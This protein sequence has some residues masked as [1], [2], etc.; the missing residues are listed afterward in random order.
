MTYGYEILLDIFGLWTNPAIW[1]VSVRILTKQ[2]AAVVYDPRIHA[3]LRLVHVS[4][5]VWL[6]SCIKGTY[7]RLEVSIANRNTAG[8]HDTCKTERNRREHTPTFF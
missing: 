6:L 4:F 2:L 7:T 5:C 3:E 1:V 8:R